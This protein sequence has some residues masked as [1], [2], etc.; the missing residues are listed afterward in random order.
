M[1]DEDAPAIGGRVD[2]LL[3]ERDVAVVSDES[4]HELVV[5]PRDID[6]A[7]AFARFAQEFLDD[8]VVL[9]RPIDATTKLPDIDEI[10][11]DV[12]RLHLVIAKELE[13]CVAFDER[14]PRW[15]SETQAVRTRRGDGAV[16]TRTFRKRLC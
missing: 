3:L 16:T 8:V 7:R 15:R 6:D 11:D 4:G 9:L 1:H 12:E 2:G 10:A 14:V 5:V 13:K